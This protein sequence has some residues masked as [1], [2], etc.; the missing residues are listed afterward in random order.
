MWSDQ[1]SGEEGDV[2]MGRRSRALQ[3][4][5]RQ[6]SERLRSRQ[7]RGWLTAGSC[8]APGAHRTSREHC[9]ALCERSGAGQGLRAERGK[10]RE[11]GVGDGEAAGRSSRQLRANERCLSSIGSEGLI[12]GAGK[13]LGKK[14]R[15]VE[16]CCPPTSWAANGISS[17]SLTQRNENSV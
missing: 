15:C 9:R 11:P 5:G 10:E 13:V 3:D 4:K 1:R 6:C 2:Q 17:G 8:S 16:I 14:K 7:E 12:R